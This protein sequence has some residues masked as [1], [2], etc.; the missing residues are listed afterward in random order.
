[1]R[2]KFLVQVLILLTLLAVVGAWLA[3]DYRSELFQPSAAR[4]GMLVI[5]AGATAEKVARLLVEKGVG[6]T[7][8]W[9]AFHMSITGQAQRLQ[10]GSYRIP[11]KVVPAEMIARIANG[12]VYSASVCIPEG[13]S[14]REI[15]QRLQVAELCAIEDFM[16]A[17]A[18]QRTVVAVAGEIRPHLEGYL[19]PATYQFEPGTDMAVMIRAMTDRF[20][21]VLAEVERGGTT[22]PRYS[23]YQ[24]LIVASI[25]E[26][27]AKKDEERPII[28]AVFYNRLANNRR[29]ESCATVLYALGIHKN[30]ISLRDLEFPSPYNTYRN[31]GLPPTPICN[32]GKASL[33]AAWRPAD[34]RYLYFVS[35]GDG[36]HAFTYTLEQHNLMIRQYQQ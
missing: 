33:I 12:E 18:E 10:A 13:L 35:K 27:E 26:K 19:F 7:A 20:R 24:R 16:K 11:P 4:P 8:R 15:A 5:P 14:R 23:F 22:M 31:D 1:M 6:V 32:P 3:G 9:L 25:V 29:L 34:E 17:T 36:S 30:E 2:N 28:A 21:A